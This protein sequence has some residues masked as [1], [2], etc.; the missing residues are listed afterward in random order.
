MSLGATKNIGDIE[1]TILTDGATSF[2]P[3]MFPGTDAE[4]TREL[5]KQAGETEIR[6]NFNANL[7]RSGGKTVLVDAGAGALMGPICGHLP[8]ALAE[9]G[10][11]AD[12]IEIFYATHLHPDHVGGALDAKGKPVFANARLVVQRAEADFW[13]GSI[14]NASDNV[15]GWQK[16]ANAV[17]SAYADRLEL[18]DGEAEIAPGMTSLPLP[19]HT[20]GHAGYRLASGNQQLLHVADIVHAPFIQVADPEIAIVF[21]LDRNAAR[22]TRKRLLDELATDGL[23]VTGGHLLAP[24]FARIERN[25]TGYRLIQS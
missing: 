2:G 25:G 24:A 13:R 16:L 6:T 8:A 14:Q 1:V 15:L 19:G 9:A 5:L 11:S 4:H 10:A 12:D 21:D 22:A 20:P 23:P 3:D 18:I 7:V 17:L